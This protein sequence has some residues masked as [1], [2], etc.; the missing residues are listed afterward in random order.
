MHNKV[1]PLYRTDCIRS[2]SQVEVFEVN[3]YGNFLENS[4]NSLINKKEPA[5]NQ[6]RSA[7]LGLKKGNNK[8][9]IELRKEAITIRTQ[10]VRP[11]SSLSNS[12]GVHKRNHFSD[13]RQIKTN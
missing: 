6:V 8:G 1:T 2:N 7:Q 12:I 3:L 9:D 13:L 11:K 5:L 10:K 4:N